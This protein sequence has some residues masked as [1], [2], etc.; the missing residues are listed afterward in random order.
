MESNKNKSQS[1]TSRQVHIEGEQNIVGDNNIVIHSSEVINQFNKPEFKNL[2]YTPK[3]PEIL[4]NPDYLDSILNIISTT[5]MIVLWGNECT[6][7]EKNQFARLLA[8]KLN[9]QSNDDL[10]IKEWLKNTNVYDIPI[11][12]M[13][14]K[15]GIFIITDIPPRSVH[16]DI[17]LI[18]NFVERKSHFLIITTNTIWEIWERFVVDDTIFEEL[19][20]RKLFSDHYLAI[21]LI[22]L[23][24]KSSFS[25]PQEIRTEFIDSFEFQKENGFDIYELSN[26]HFSN[27]WTIRD[28]AE[29]LKSYDDL[30]KFIRLLPED[31]TQ[32]FTDKFIEE[33]I[34]D[35]MEKDLDFLHWY[36]NG[37]DQR[38][39]RLLLGATLLSGLYENQF[40][41]AMEDLVEND[42]RI[43]KP[44]FDSFDYE[45][46][47]VLRNYAIDV[48]ETGKIERK[49]EINSNLKRIIFR[50][51]WYNHQRLVV[52]SI[53]G[54]L[55]LVKNSTLIK[56]VD[57]T[58][59]EIKITDENFEKLEQLDIPEY[60]L[61]KISNLRDRTYNHRNDLLS[62]IY[63]EIGANSFMLFVEKIK[64]VFDKTKW[65]AQD[66]DFREI[67]Q[68]SKKSQLY[69][70]LVKVNLIHNVVGS[71]LRL[72]AYESLSLVEEALFYYACQY[73]L[74][75]RILAALS[76]AQWKHH[77]REIEGE[78]IYAQE[79][80]QILNR[81][82][83]KPQV[84]YDPF[85]GQLSKEKSDFIKRNKR[86]LYSTI[87]LTIGFAATYDEPNECSEELLSLLDEFI[88]PLWEKEYVLQEW[89][90]IDEVFGSHVVSLLMK[91]HLEQIHDNELIYRLMIYPDSRR[92]ISHE[93]AITYLKEPVLFNEIIDEIYNICEHLKR[94]KKRFKRK[95]KF[96]KGKTFKD[97]EFARI[98]G[99]RSYNR[100]NCM[101]SVL[102]AVYGNLHFIE[103][104][105]RLTA[106]ETFDRLK[107]FY[108]T[109]S[110]EED[111][112]NAVLDAV[113]TQI[114]R[115]F[116]NIQREIQSILNIFSF[117]NLI[118]IMPGFFPHL[119]QERK[120]MYEEI[121][122]EKK[123]ILVNKPDTEID[124]QLFNPESYETRTETIL[125]KWI[126]WRNNSFRKLAFITMLGANLDISKNEENDKEIVDSFTQLIIKNDPLKSIYSI[127]I[128]PICFLGFGIHI[129]SHLL[130]TMIS[131]NE[132]YRNDIDTLAKNWQS[133]IN[134]ISIRWLGLSLR[135][136]LHLIN[137][138]ELVVTIY[139]IITSIL[140]WKISQFP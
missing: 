37:L 68:T 134:K 133:N 16:Y 11:F 72:I 120:K 108:N 61:T 66:S 6:R 31:R 95:N 113:K 33:L 13:K 76:L 117:E 91:F 42:W 114:A 140:V 94:E 19:T 60:I 125:F 12:L 84:I 9:S 8:Y 69:G 103:G 59:T 24:Y 98:K 18:Q 102:I 49:I 44:S 137:H 54:L 75:M 50:E 88:P 55:N 100:R 21:N 38:A 26:F 105:G 101:I 32:V 89:E 128:A 118:R 132:K 15:R 131:L 40:F 65:V 1:E 80:Y 10:P 64:V 41:A 81:W 58:S 48:I 85:G 22:E 121:A 139:L 56:S 47:E 96:L 130:P 90:T 92:A 97:G 127:L 83:K 104:E 129:V 110:N 70:S 2:F 86:F 78:D 25:L 93:L 116:H 82:H 67:F 7:N 17:E 20:K 112:I 115:D 53:Q 5:G 43:R 122:E 99:F 39:Q 79:L 71:A 123:A 46:L 52:N 14:E 107:F 135:I 111:L 4:F 126:F 109:E 27:S 3:E 74:Q 77:E 136:S 29:N 36:H 34:R 87:V 138:I 63:D 62:D 119:K 23:L 45:D 106:E 35:V 30:E 51:C 124:K 73:N 57:T 28:I